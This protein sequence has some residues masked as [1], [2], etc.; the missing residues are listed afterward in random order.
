LRWFHF[1][2]SRALV[3]ICDSGNSNSNSMRECTLATD[4]IYKKR[5]CD[6]QIQLIGIYESSLSDWG[7]QLKYL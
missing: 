2:N 3:M 5:I 4:I 7:I 1:G 6:K